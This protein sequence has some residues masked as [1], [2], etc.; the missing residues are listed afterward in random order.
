MDL[1]SKELDLSSLSYEELKS[2]AEKCTKC[3]LAKGRTNVVFGNGP[4][5]CDLMLIGEAPGADEDEQGLPFVGRSG[6]LLTQILASVGIKRPDNIYI[7]NTVKC[8]PPDNRA[9]LPK[10]QEACASFL[11]AQIRLVKPKIILLAGAPAVKAILKTDEPITGLRGKWLILPGSEISVMPLFHPAYLLRNPSKEKGKPKWLTWQ[12]VQ[13]VKNALDFHKKV[14]EL[15]K[16][17]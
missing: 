4:V 17:Q 8:R 15:A 7:A 2:L 10:E 11:Q 14:A 9:P 1:F 3:A 16:N 6:Q 13:E 12:D 5:P